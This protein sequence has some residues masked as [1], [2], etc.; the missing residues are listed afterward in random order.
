MRSDARIESTGGRSCGIGETFGGF[1]GGG[2]S[3]Q[4]AIG[5]SQF[6]DAVNHPGGA[7]ETKSAAG[8]F[9]T[10]ETIY[11][12]AQAATIEFGQFGE[13]EN[14]PSVAVA[15]QLIERQLE[16]FALDAQLERSG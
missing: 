10:G 3:F 15:E 14:H 12:F 1:T 5:V 11:N 2:V 6:Q 4:K 8:G 16:L 7:G 13:I 9:Q